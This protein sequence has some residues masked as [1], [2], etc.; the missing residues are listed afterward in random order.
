M[1]APAKRKK[2]RERERRGEEPGN[3]RKWPEVQGKGQ[4]S[5]GKG[6]KW[7]TKFLQK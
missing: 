1:L 5:T 3:L 6:Q 4:R 2:E 7:A